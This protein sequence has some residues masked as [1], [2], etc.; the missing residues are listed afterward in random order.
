MANK[1]LIILV[2]LLIIT[3]TLLAFNI[4]YSNKSTDNA[5]KQIGFEEYKGGVHPVCSDYNDN[6]WYVK[7]DCNRWG[8]DCIA[9]PITIGYVETKE[10]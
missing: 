8:V 6:Q 7:M 2:S 10:E 5:C 4:H 1:I 9:K 3:I